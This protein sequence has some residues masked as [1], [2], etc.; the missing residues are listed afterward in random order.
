MLV[1][2]TKGANQPDALILS[3]RRAVSN[4]DCPPEDAISTGLEDVRDS[5]SWNGRLR[6]PDR[7]HEFPIPAERPSQPEDI[8]T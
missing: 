2:Q 4:D 1:R 3:R 6:K 8:L 5:I 7:L